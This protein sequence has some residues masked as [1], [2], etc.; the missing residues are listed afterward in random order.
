MKHIFQ[1]SIIGL[2]LSVLC[3]STTYGQTPINSLEAARKELALLLTDTSQI[4]KPTFEFKPGGSSLIAFGGNNNVAQVLGKQILPDMNNGEVF[5]KY[6][7]EQEKRYRFRLDA[8]VNDSIPDI[9]QTNLKSEINHKLSMI[10]SAE[11]LGTPKRVSMLWL[12]DADGKRILAASTA[13][14]LKNPRYGLVDNFRQG[15]AR[16]KK[17]QVFGFLN[18]SGDEF[19]PSQYE[20][21]EPF[22]DGKALVK[23]ADW[24]FV[25][26][27]GQESTML[28][29]VVDAKAIN[30]GYSMVKLKTAAKDVYKYAIVDN[31]YDYT[32]KTLSALYDEIK[33][34][35]KEELFLV[36]NGQKYGLIKINGSVRL[37]IDYDQI[38][39]TSIPNLIKIGINNKVGLIDTLGNMKLRPTFDELNNFNENGL[40]IAREGTNSFLIRQKDM[41]VSSPYLKI[42]DFDQSGLAVVQNSSRLFGLLDKNLQTIKE[43]SFISVSEFNQYGLAA[44][45]KSINACGF[46]NTLGQEV[47]PMTY[48][49][50]GKFSKSGMVVVDQVLADCKNYGGSK[51]CIVESVLDYKGNVIIP[52]A[53]GDGAN[54]KYAITDTLRNNYIVVKAFVQTSET[55]KLHYH[56]INKVNLFRIT[57]THYE[58]IRGYDANFLFSVRKNDKWGLIDTTGK[59]I[60]KCQYKSLMSPRDGLYGVMNDQDK[61][62]YIDKKGKLQINHEYDTAMAFNGG[63][64]I[65]SKGTNKMGIINRFNAKVI[66]C[67]FTMIEY[68]DTDRLQL[69]SEK[70]EKFTVD[71]KGECLENCDKLD[72]IRTQANQK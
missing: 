9:F 55:K 11:S 60:V 62:G 21:A 71:T 44:A 61:I 52:K 42:N 57:N 3:T 43:P 10:K 7:K 54:V 72:Q 37:G 33:A 66:P 18:L 24:Y 51:D 20:Q 29:N 8:V 32:K 45:C 47:I 15:F 56:L 36:R 5:L 64:A 41:K 13:N 50:V 70:G 40:A 67:L 39:P 63:I 26:T 69:T 34:Y 1:L 14:L 4:S 30:F 48:R 17:D 59:E 27:D 16:I 28:E 38:E 65:V 25:N 49:Q 35:N 19:I 6:L 46:I 68:I 58:S 53:E 23:K 2:L 22:N 31:N 12:A